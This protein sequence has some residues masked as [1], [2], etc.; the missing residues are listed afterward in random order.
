MEGT[1]DTDEDELVPFIHLA[2]LTAN[3]VRYLRPV[4]ESGSDEPSNE[5]SKSDDGHDAPEECLGSE[6]AIVDGEC[7]PLNKRPATEA[8][9]VTPNCAGM[10]RSG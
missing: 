9:G 7:S 1:H 8:A 6:I 4:D 3:V 10:K 5:E 2:A